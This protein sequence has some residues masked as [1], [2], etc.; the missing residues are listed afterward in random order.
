MRKLLSVLLAT[1]LIVTAFAAVPATAATVTAEGTAVTFDE[2]YYKSTDGIYGAAL[3]TVTFANDEEHGTV[4]KYGKISKWASYNDGKWPNAVR[5]GDSTGTAAFVF[6][7]N[8][9]YT[10]SL[11]IKKVTASSAF[12]IYLFALAEYNGLTGITINNKYFPYDWTGAGASDW[13]TITKTV[14]CSF[15]E[16]DTATLA[17]ALYTS[18]GVYENQEIYIDNI[19]VQKINT[20]STYVSFDEDYYKSTDGIFGAALDTVT[21]ANDEE[22]G[23]VAKYDKISKWASNNDGKW[24]NAVRI[25]DITGENPFMFKK[26]ERYEISV[27]IKADKMD[28]VFNMYLAELADGVGL[29]GITINSN[30]LYYEYIGSASEWTRITKVIDTSTFTNDSAALAFVL[31]VRAGKFENQEIYIDNITVKRMVNVT[32][33]TNNGVEAETKAYTVGTPIAKIPAYLAGAELEGWYYDATLTK[34]ANGDTVT[35]NTGALYAKWKSFTYDADNCGLDYVSNTTIAEYEGY[36][37]S[38]AYGMK[39]SSNG[40]WPEKLQLLNKDGTAFNTVPGHT[41]SLSLKFKA[42]KNSDADELYSDHSCISIDYTSSQKYDANSFTTAYDLVEETGGKTKAYSKP[43]VL[44]ADSDDKEAYKTVTYNIKA[45]ASSELPV[46]I[47]TR[48]VAGVTYFDDIKITDLTAQYTAKAEDGTVLASGYYGESYTLPETDENGETNRIYWSDSANGTEVTGGMLTGNAT[49]YPVTSQIALTKTGALVKNSKPVLSAKLI[50]DGIEGVA[51]DNGL[52]LNYITIGNTRYIVSEIGVIVAPAAALDGAELTAEN[53]IK[54]GGKVLKNTELKY[55]ALNNGKLAV[56][57]E[58]TVANAETEY[59]VVGYV[60]YGISGKTV[61]SKNRSGIKLSYAD[62]AGLDKTNLY[63]VNYNGQTY[64]LTFNDEFN[65]GSNVYDKWNCRSDVFTDDSGN[66]EYSVPEMATVSDGKLCLASVKDGNKMKFSEISG[67]HLFT[68]GYIEFAAQYANIANLKGA[69][70]L[71]GSGLKDEELAV[72]PSES[73]KYVIP[74]IDIIEFVSKSLTY[75]T[76][77]S[78][79]RGITTSKLNRISIDKYKKSSDFTLDSIN[80]ALSLDLTQKHV[81][82]FE[83]TSDVMR[84]YID[85]KLLFEVN[86]SD[87]SLKKD[88]SGVERTNEEIQALFDNPV[89]FRLSAALGTGDTATEATSYIDYIRVYE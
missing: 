24:P 58:I 36:A 31:Y 15:F 39:Y 86:K 25:A 27:D 66:I 50:F 73:S 33:N 52:T 17:V 59:A 82:G 26:G 18:K 5:I 54:H 30:L 11:D 75:S 55:T 80:R 49:F 85:R 19:R 74:E 4:A 3:D 16:N 2:D 43:K 65:N 76:L 20:D 89:Y 67:N 14:D 72:K 35:S 53:Y 81:Y 79:A 84:F 68:H 69:F 28:N 60:K 38:K 9:R 7:K 56:E 47:T 61:Y 83:R 87:S 45:N 63:Q 8:A 44:F 10:I 71:V 64:T 48:S 88:D 42:K 34:P 23:T 62:A 13:T 40:L 41:Y 51:A 22:H 21:F 57:S 6:E 32:L 78:W 37:N 1:A 46:Y 77:H 29:A 70:W 12:N